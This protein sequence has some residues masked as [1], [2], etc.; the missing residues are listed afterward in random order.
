MEKV[1]NL[2]PSSTAAD[3]S[4]GPIMELKPI[5][6]PLLDRMQFK[7]AC[8]GPYLSLDVMLFNCC[9]IIIIVY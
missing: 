2:I 9:I 5:L 3:G 6:P 8:V 1:L 4:V 7:T